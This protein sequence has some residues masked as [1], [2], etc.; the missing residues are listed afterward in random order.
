[1]YTFHL[2]NIMASSFDEEWVIVNVSKLFG[3]YRC[4]NVKIQKMSKHIS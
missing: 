3:E 1:M 4:V 2:T